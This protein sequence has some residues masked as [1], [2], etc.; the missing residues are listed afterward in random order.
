MNGSESA[1]SRVD[2]EALAVELVENEG[3]ELQILNANVLNFRLKML[4]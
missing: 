2:H 4:R 1:K 3:K